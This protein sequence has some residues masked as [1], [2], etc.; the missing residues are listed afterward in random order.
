MQLRVG[1][2]GYPTWDLRVTFLGLPHSGGLYPVKME[3]I[4]T[5]AGYGGVV[6]EGTLHTGP[7]SSICVLSVGNVCPQ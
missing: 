5:N 3:S 1:R 2:E 6:Q 7:V 4:I